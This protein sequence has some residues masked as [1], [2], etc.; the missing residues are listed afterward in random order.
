[1]R[2]HEPLIHMFNKNE[3][4][5][6]ETEW[7]KDVR[8]RRNAILVGDT[9][10]DVDM[11]SGS[12]HDVVLRVG[13]LN[14]SKAAPALLPLY[15]DAFDVVILHDGPFDFVRELLAEILRK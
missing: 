12:D 9:L 13:F 15:R 14:D 7:A 10:Q 3:S 1:V 2:F 8:A 5:L 4:H 6:G 11:A